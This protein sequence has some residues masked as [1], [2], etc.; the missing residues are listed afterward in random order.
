MLA[1]TEIEGKLNAWKENTVGATIGRLFLDKTNGRPMLAPTEIEGKSN[2]WK[3][4]IVG[5]TIG[6]PYIIL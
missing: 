1:P 3:E 2:A 4:N 6:R 5:A